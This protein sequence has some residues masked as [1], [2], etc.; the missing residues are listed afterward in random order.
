MLPADTNS[1]LIPASDCT[2][3]APVT[4]TLELLFDE[5]PV[6]MVELSL[7]LELPLDEELVLD[8]EVEVV[9]ELEVDVFRR[10]WGW[11]SRRYAG[12]RVSGRNVVR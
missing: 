10:S 11:N 12:I 4:T 6:V 9:P 5:V 8:V 3:N 7:E 2:V 1:P